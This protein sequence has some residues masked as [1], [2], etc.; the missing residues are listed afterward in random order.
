MSTTVLKLVLNDSFG[1]GWDGAEYIMNLSSNDIN[2]QFTY[3]AT[4]GSGSSK[5][6]IIPDVPYGSYD[7]DVGGG[8][9][10][11][12]ISW[13]LYDYNSNVLLVSG[14]GE[15]S[16]SDFEILPP[17]HL[18]IAGSIHTTNIVLSFDDIAE[19]N[20][21]KEL[22]LAETF[23]EPVA[24]LEFAPNCFVVFCQ[25]LN[26]ITHFHRAEP[27]K[28]FMSTSAKTWLD[29][30][31]NLTDSRFVMEEVRLVNKEPLEACEIVLLNQVTNLPQVRFVER[32]YFCSSNNV[33][34]TQ[35]DYLEGSMMIGDAVSISLPNITL[36]DGFIGHGFINEKSNLY[37]PQ[38]PPTIRSYDYDISF[39]DTN[40]LH[41]GPNTPYNSSSNSLKSLFNSYWD[42]NIKDR[43]IF[44]SIN[45]LSNAITDTDEN[46]DETNFSVY[47]KSKLATKLKGETDYL[48]AVS[49]LEDLASGVE[50]RKENIHLFEDELA[51]GAARFAETDNSL[52][53]VNEQALY[54]KTLAIDDVIDQFQSFAD[55]YVNY[56]TVNASLDIERQAYTDALSN[57]TAN[58]TNNSFP[59]PL[60]TH[61]SLDANSIVNNTHKSYALLYIE[62][63]DKV[64][65]VIGQLDMA[66]SNMKAAD[67]QFIE[68]MDLLY[69]AKGLIVRGMVEQI[70]IANMATGLYKTATKVF[71]E[72]ASTAIIYDSFVP[73]TVYAKSISDNEGLYKPIKDIHS[74]A[75]DVATNSI[76]S[77]NILLLNQYNDVAIK[78]EALT[79]I[80]EINAVNLWVDGET[81][82]LKTPQDV[83][84]Y[85]TDV[86]GDSKKVV[87]CTR[88]SPDPSDDFA[89]YGGLRHKTSSADP[90]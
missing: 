66:A 43:H 24:D 22:L 87:E 11:G 75:M 65:A 20:L 38:G 57:A 19:F 84:F 70:Y 16:M 56:Q 3:S 35:N 72:I 44:E 77:E 30:N 52:N 26:A 64:I 55:I 47:M 10:D 33:D 58:L 51:N 27:L 79:I 7:I 68:N 48:D 90:I 73:E 5:T 18:F 15:A 37:T 4:L 62:E 78:M 53:I 42:M 1:D 17:N 9:Y 69:T 29:T 28:E 71:N 81:I 12:E 36:L 50:T 59:Q 23:G 8:G 14:T 39:A 74:A 86:N 2:N 89:V 40:M 61:T 82:Y 60:D 49:D 45:M 13:E 63:R 34:L 21:Q 46:G 83:E 6:V 67:T 54:T 85:V 76:N 31:V 25:D 32:S 41:P 80:I 88:T